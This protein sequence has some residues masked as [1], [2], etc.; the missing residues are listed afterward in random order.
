MNS[1]HAICIVGLLSYNQHLSAIIIFAVFF[2]IPLRFINLLAFRFFV[3]FIKRYK[4]Y[5]YFYNHFNNI[6]VT[7]KQINYLWMCSCSC[8]LT[9]SSGLAFS[10]VNLYGVAHR[11]KFCSGQEK[12]VGNTYFHSTKKSLPLFATPNPY[13]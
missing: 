13:P 3:L 11:Q 7:I 4:F 8:V 1:Q 12:I 2:Y 10:P 5:S 6:L 9:S